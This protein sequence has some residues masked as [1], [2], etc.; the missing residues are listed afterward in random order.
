[1]KLLGIIA[2]ML[3]IYMLSFLG[4]CFGSGSG[5]NACA[6]IEDKDITYSSVIL[7]PPVQRVVDSKNIEPINTLNFKALLDTYSGWRTDTKIV[8]SVSV[9]GCSGD[10]ITKSK[11]YSKS[12][13]Y[14]HVEMLKL[15]KVPYTGMSMANHTATVNII[16]GPFYDSGGYPG[17][18][19]WT[20]KY[21]TN[22]FVP[23][24]EDLDIR[25]TFVRGVYSKK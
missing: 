15:L 24:N 12:S 10:N 2:N 8:V 3:G 6:W 18:V 25:G 4:S 14:S 19:I 17:Y 5:S 1:M 11:T 16:S 13:N 22:T 23:I 20:K 7:R 9:I 21:D